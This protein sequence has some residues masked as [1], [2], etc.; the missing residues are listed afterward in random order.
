MNITISK[1]ESPAHVTILHLEGKLDGAN[2]EGL[3]E[4]AKGVYENGVLDLILDLSKVI[5]ISSAGIAA[6]HQVAL[7][8]RGE[9]RSD[10]ADGW[11]VFHAIDRDHGSRT[12]EHVKLFCPGS[13][14][15]EA[16]ELTGFSSLFEI[17]TDLPLAVAS[18]QHAESIIEADLP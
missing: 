18:F 16:L 9:Y 4:E 14:V 17:F 2:Y 12:Q 11:A 13:P 5:F 8:F 15:R 3:I 10:H 6:L 7:L 1:T